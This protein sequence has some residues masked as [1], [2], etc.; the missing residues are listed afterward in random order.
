[1]SWLSQIKYVCGSVIESESV[2]KWCRFLDEAIQSIVTGCVVCWTESLWNNWTLLIVKYHVI[3]FHFQ[4]LFQ[5]KRISNI[6]G[7]HSIYD[8]AA[9]YK[10]RA[11]CSLKICSIKVD[12]ILFRS[13]YQKSFQGKPFLC[14]SWSD[15][16]WF[17]SRRSQWALLLLKTESIL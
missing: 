4:G 5:I 14:V 8:V 12:G 3:H 15:I 13:P 16:S 2:L 7:K 6:W 1:M 10:I 17:Y 9:L 11:T